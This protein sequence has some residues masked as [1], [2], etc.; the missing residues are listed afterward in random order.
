LRGVVKRFPTQTVKPTSSE[1]ETIPDR[2]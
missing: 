1:K 2:K